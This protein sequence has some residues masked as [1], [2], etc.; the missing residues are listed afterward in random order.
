MCD[1]QNISGSQADAMVFAYLVNLAEESPGI[2]KLLEALKRDLQKQTR[3]DPPA[4]IETKLHRCDDAISHLVHTL[5]QDGVG[6]AFIQHVNNRI[7]ALE[8]ERS[9]L[10]QEREQL[11]MK[12][13][14]ITGLHLEIE[15]LAGSLSDLKGLLRS[16]SVQEKR[17]LIHLLVQRI[18]WDGKNLHVFLDLASNGTESL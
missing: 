14:S 6:A 4:C 12:R 17:S 9:S 1:C 2:C 11:Q 15:R 10:L 13:N 18:V 5:S 3:E 16:L 8:Q 7:E